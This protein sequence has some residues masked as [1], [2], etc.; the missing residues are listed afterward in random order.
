[1]VGFVVMSFLNEPDL[2]GVKTAKMNQFSKQL[3]GQ[4]GVVVKTSF[5]PHLKVI[6]LSLTYS[7][8]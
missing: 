8:K 3:V 4:E 1:M 5:S 6:E 7:K 2:E